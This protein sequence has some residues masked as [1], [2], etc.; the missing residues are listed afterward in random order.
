MSERDKIHE[1]IKSINEQ[2]K[3]LR[4]EK[5]GFLISDMLLSD[6]DQWYEEKEVEDII[7]RRPKKT[8]K[9][10]IGLVCWKE[11]WADE[12]TGEVVT[13]NRNVRIREDGEW[14]GYYSPANRKKNK[15]LPVL[16]FINKPN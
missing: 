14:L 3:R 1:S 2:I 8:K 12:D 10:L 7:S 5:D 15:P 9:V 13:I 16:D 4:K 11:D 6:E